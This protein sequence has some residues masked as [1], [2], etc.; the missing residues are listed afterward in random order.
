MKAKLTLALLLSFFTMNSQFRKKLNLKVKNTTS[1]SMIVLAKVINKDTSPPNPNKTDYKIIC[2]LDGKNNT[3]DFD[4]SFPF[5]LSKKQRIAI[6]SKINDEFYTDVKIY[7][8]TY[9]KNNII[10]ITAPN[11]NDKIVNDEVTLNSLKSSFN[12]IDYKGY[13]E[14]SPSEF[15]GSFLLFKGEE[16]IDKIYPYSYSLND[17]KI[18]SKG[19]EGVFRSEVLSREILGKLSADFPFGFAIKAAFVNDKFMQFEWDIQGVGKI[20]WYPSDKNVRTITKA[21][22]AIDKQTTDRILRKYNS[23]KEKIKLLFVSEAFQIE[24]VSVQNYQMETA[25]LNFQGTVYKTANSD[26]RYKKSSNSSYKYKRENLITNALGINVTDLL[27]YSSWLTEIQ[28]EKNIEKEKI[29]AA[30]NNLKERFP[31]LPDAQKNDTKTMLAE[32]IKFKSQLSLKTDETLKE[33]NALEEIPLNQIE[34]N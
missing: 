21:F 5:K 13:K 25:D 34:E 31:E 1:L 18:I 2:E 26:L 29:I 17:T 14:V 8:R 12:I 33:Q 15:L 9:I 28:S 3:N 27:E 19:K 22:F 30:Y 20:A 7:D 6:T 11:K 10:K 4:C 16:L 24:K 23:S 32:I